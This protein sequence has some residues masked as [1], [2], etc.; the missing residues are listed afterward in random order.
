M[1]HG[2]NFS[3]PRTPLNSPAKRTLC[4]S[5]SLDLHP[6]L[7]LQTPQIPSNSDHKALNRGTLGGL[8]NMAHMVVSGKCGALFGSPYNE[9]HNKTDPILGPLFVEPLA[10]AFL[11]QGC[12]QVDANPGRL[13]FQEL[14]GEPSQGAQPMA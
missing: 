6:Q 5:R 4:D 13:A 1:S 12:R 10:G 8:Q 11:G 7:P 9:D 2:Q 14:R 3:Q